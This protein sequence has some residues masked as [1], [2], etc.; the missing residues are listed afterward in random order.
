MNTEVNIENAVLV[1]IDILGYK[2]LIENKNP[3]DIYNFINEA[4]EPK[5]KVASDPDHP[6]CEYAKKIKVQVLSDSV[7]MF[8]DL[9]DVEE[10]GRIFLNYIC[11]FCLNFIANTGLLLRGGIAV[12]SYFQKELTSPKNQFI[13]SKALVAAYQLEQEAYYP[14][15]LLADNLCASERVF[16]EFSITDF[17]KVKILDVYHDS[18]KYPTSYR[19]RIFNGIVESL[20]KN[21]GI[22]RRILKKQFYFQQFH[23]RRV[24]EI[25][26]LSRHENND[27]LSNNKFVFDLKRVCLNRYILRPEEWKIITPTWFNWLRWFLMVGT[28]GYLAEKTNNIGLQIIYGISYIA[29]YMFITTTISDILNIK[30]IKNQAFN[31]IITFCIAFIILV[32]TYL[33]LHQSLKDLLRSR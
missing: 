23:N 33:V 7:I 10:M 1:F 8:I 25:L 15:I 24:R 5:D 4:L 18:D 11:E 21:K 28:V 14:R 6:A 22:G 32:T 30:F 29:F 2:K 3:G 27:N 31:K 16:N 17:D 12:G 20:G 9:K 26:K 19:N 13:F